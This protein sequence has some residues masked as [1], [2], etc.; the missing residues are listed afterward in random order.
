MCS[1]DICAV[2]KCHASYFYHYTFS[3]V[4]RFFSSFSRTLTGHTWWQKIAL[5]THIVATTRVLYIY[6]Y[7]CTS[8]AG[9]ENPLNTVISSKLGTKHDRTA[10][11]R[12]RNAVVMCVCEC[13][14]AQY[15]GKWITHVNRRSVKNW[16]DVAAT[17]RHQDD[18][19]SLGGWWWHCERELHKTVLDVLPR[20]DTRHHADKFRRCRRLVKQLISDRSPRSANK[21]AVAARSY[22][23]QTRYIS[24]VNISNIYIVI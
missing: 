5:H 23:E 17:G 2:D 20:P 22:I 24:G 21:Q 16:A 19:T 10:K 11:I 9:L 1:A 4:Q 13:V 6:L 14:A 3:D 7:C 15:I 12:K 8:R 18:S